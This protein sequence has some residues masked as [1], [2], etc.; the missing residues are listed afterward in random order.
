MLNSYMLFLS[1]TALNV[2]FL[3]PFFVV[4]PK[5][6]TYLFFYNLLTSALNLKDTY[7]IPIGWLVLDGRL[8]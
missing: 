2:A 4:R 7:P 8:N 6:V 3:K 5:V 1:W